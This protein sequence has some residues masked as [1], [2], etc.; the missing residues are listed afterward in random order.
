MNTQAKKHSLTLHHG[1]K[2]KK[3]FSFAS[4]FSEYKLTPDT[5]GLVLE[6]GAKPFLSGKYLG[7]EI[8]FNGSN[9]KNVDFVCDENHLP[10]SASYDCVISPLSLHFAK[11]PKTHLNQLISI[12]KPGGQ[13]LL[14]AF[15]HYSLYEIR[16]SRPENTYIELPDFIHPAQ[17]KTWLPSQGQRE[18]TED[19][20]S[21]HYDSPFA[22]FDDFK[23]S[24]LKKTLKPQGKMSSAH[25]RKAIEHFEGNLTFQLITLTYNKPHS[26]RDE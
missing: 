12:L 5:N 24:N 23:N 3:L 18:I 15:G 1:S 25:V 21:L 4:Q 19:W 10:F 7:A 2:L 13:L 9:P 8:F 17:L 14:T 22:F 20:I 26:P 11:S 6:I 16:S